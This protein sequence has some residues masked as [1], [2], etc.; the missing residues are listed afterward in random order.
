M[1][2]ACA[3]TESLTAAPTE[4]SIR[5]TLTR[6]LFEPYRIDLELDGKAY[7]GEW[8][9]TAADPAQRAATPYPQRKQAGQV[10]ATL[11]AADGS[12]LR[13]HWLTR[14]GH[15]VGSCGNASGRYQLSRD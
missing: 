3:T 10:D 14:G 15:A 8:R 13:C 1:T 5:A 7:V 12:A 6:G 2:G 4:V 9:T 11:L